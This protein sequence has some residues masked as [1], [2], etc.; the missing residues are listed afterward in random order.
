LPTEQFQRYVIDPNKAIMER[1]RKK[2]P[3]VPII[4]FP[5]GAGQGYLDFATQTRPNGLSL[6]S[7]VNREW[8]CK[9][10][11]ADIV[12]QGNLDPIILCT[13]PATI[14]KET[15]KMLADFQDRRHNHPMII[16]LGHGVLKYTPPE[17][18][19]HFVACVRGKI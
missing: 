5:R 12:L 3:N 17:H 1:I 7:F 6:D 10:L 8:A 11:P 9:E 19:A 16:N 18:V 13:D 15:K 2:H 4:A 14:Q